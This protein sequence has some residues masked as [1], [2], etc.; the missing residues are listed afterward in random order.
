MD[1]IY[2]KIVNKTKKKLCK[3]KQI[4]TSTKNN[5]QKYQLYIK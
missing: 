3:S 5:I 1:H 2:K 4:L